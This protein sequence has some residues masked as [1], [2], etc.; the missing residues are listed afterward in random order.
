MSLK[1]DVRAGTPTTVY[2][3]ELYFVASTVANGEELWKTNGTSL[4]TQ[5]VA[6]VAPGSDGSGISE[7]E[8]VDGLGVFF[9]A[10]ENT[11]S[12]FQ[13]W[14]TDGVS[15]TA[16][17]VKNIPEG[18]PEFLTAHNNHLYF[19]A[20]DATV[21]TELWISDGTDSGTDVVEDLLEGFD[22]EEGRPFGSYPIHLTS[23]GTDLFFATKESPV[24]GLYRTNTSMSGV[25]FV[26]AAPSIFHDV[27][28]SPLSVLNGTLFFAAAGF[29]TGIE[30]W[31][32][33]G[34]STGTQIIAEVFAGTDG[35]R[36]FAFTMFDNS[37]YFAA[38]GSL[39][40]DLWVHP[41]QPIASAP[42]PVFAD[43]SVYSFLLD[44]RESFALETATYE[45]DIDFDGTFQVDA[46]GATALFDNTGEAPSAFEY[47]FNDGT[48][49]MPVVLRVTDRNGNTSI[50]TT[51]L[52][53]QSNTA[54]NP[55]MPVPAGS[56]RSPKTSTRR[57]RKGKRTSHERASRTGGGR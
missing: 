1:R 15:G 4:G 38:E 25:E 24:Q 39:G 57:P 43:A 8:A 51:Y 21:G 45:W 56:K 12:G 27:D 30:V 46:T 31:T 42:S 19:R 29:G 32:S 37:L 55:D 17:V 41:L 34:T 11:A 18:N 40:K 35:G 22:Y 6:D 53:V 10:R 3:G 2:G 13:L 33:D 47:A 28:S 36:P 14:L 16:Q 54:P 5:L 23:V 9:V 26:S 20:Y 44:G 52:T 49:A 48:A 50:D 7:I